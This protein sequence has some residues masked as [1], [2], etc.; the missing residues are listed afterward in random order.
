MMNVIE[1]SY[2]AVLRSILWSLNPIKKRVIKTECEVHK[3]INEQGISILKNDGYS[4]AYNLMAAYV[5]DINAG[6][7]WVD[8]DFKSANHF[9]SPGKNRGLFGRSNAQRE[10]KIYYNKA[11]CSYH[12][13]KIKKAMFYLGAACHLAQDLTVPQH[14]NIKLMSSHRRYEQ[15]VIRVYKKHDDFRVNRRGVYLK[16]AYDYIRYNSMK[17]IETYRN[18]SN[19]RDKIIRFYKI[20]SII[21]VLAQKTTA[22]LMLNFYKDTARIRPNIKRRQEIRLYKIKDKPKDMR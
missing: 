10:F 1:R 15:W 22:G 12:N 17:A 9:Y 6:A 21:L 19:E 14:A 11:L 4:K 3:F 5:N 18:F 13:K 20:T 2:S 7:V 16:S 8:Q